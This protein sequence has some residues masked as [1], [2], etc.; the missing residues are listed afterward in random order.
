[1]LCLSTL[2]QAPHTHYYNIIEIPEATTS[3]MFLFVT[4]AKC[5]RTPNTLNPAYNDVK[6]HVEV[7]STTCLKMKEYRGL[8]GQKN[9]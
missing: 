3:E 1:M 5:P 8:N 7:K 9:P 2:V 6:L 4:N